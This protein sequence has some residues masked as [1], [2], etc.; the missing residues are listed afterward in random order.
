MQKIRK[1]VI[2][3][4]GFGTRFLPI[5]KT[6]QKEMLPILNKP[7]ID[8]VVEDCLKAG[9]TDII[10]VMN[11]HNYQPLHYYRK[12]KRLQQYLAK[13]GKSDLYKQI[14]Q[15]PTKANFYFVK[16]TDQ[17]SYGTSIPVKLAKKY[18]ADEPAFLYLTGD[19]FIFFRDKNRSLVKE[20][21]ETYN[22]SQ[23]KA[24]MVCIKRPKKELYR[25]GVAEIKNN[26]GFTYLTKL[27]EKPEPNQV[28]SNLVNVSK[29]ILP[30]EVFSLIEN[31]KPNPQTKEYYITDIISHLAKTEKV[32]VQ[33]AGGCFLNSGEPLTWLKANL[34]AAGQNPELKKHLEEFLQNDWHDLMS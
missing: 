2:T 32:I 14:Q 13:T 22:A 7:T 8:Y 31:Q 19:D 17:D 27:I 34:I 28:S 11:E 30:S 10:I 25:Y 3:C 6:I 29:Y 24:A 16:Q 23:A 15:I 26:N 20:L 5:S 18:V 4:A 21:I 33:A 1:A 9:I 12:N